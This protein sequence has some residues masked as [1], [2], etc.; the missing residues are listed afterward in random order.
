MYLGPYRR[1]SMLK[2]ATIFS[3]KLLTIF[4]KIFIIGASSGPKYVLCASYDS[5]CR[6]SLFSLLELFF[7]LTVLVIFSL[8]EKCPNTEFFMVRIFPYSDWIRRFTRSACLILQFGIKINKNRVQKRGRRKQ[9]SQI[10]SNH[11][12]I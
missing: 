5:A 3:E 7:F 6:L 2:R 9:S 1:T 4:A 10:G 8:N 11:Y 12:R